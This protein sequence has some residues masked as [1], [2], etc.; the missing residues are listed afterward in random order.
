MWRPL[1]SRPDAR[2]ND[3]S[4]S[5]CDTVGAGPRI[6]AGSGRNSC[7][8]MPIRSRISRSTVSLQVFQYAESVSSRSPVGLSVSTADICTAANRG[9][10]RSRAL[11]SM[12]PQRFSGGSPRSSS[13]SAHSGT[14]AAGAPGDS[15][16]CRS[17]CMSCDTIALQSSSIPWNDGMCAYWRPAT[18]VSAWSESRRVLRAPAHLV[19]NTARLDIVTHGLRNGVHFNALLQPGR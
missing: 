4:G 19:K 15:M 9:C 6:S 5:N 11:S 3:A 13:K 2:I 17:F 18:R 16:R 14:T 1:A 10:S 8:Y 12:R 7:L